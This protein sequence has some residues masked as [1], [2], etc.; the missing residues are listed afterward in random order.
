MEYDHYH[1]E[2]TI[3]IVLCNVGV[4]ANTN[5]DFSEGVP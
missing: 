4:L 3:I 2:A 5:G 1:V